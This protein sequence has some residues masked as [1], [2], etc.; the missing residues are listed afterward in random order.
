MALLLAS[1]LLLLAYSVITGSSIGRFV[2]LLPLLEISY[3]VS[4]GRGRPAVAA[5]WSA[6]W[7]STSSAHG[8]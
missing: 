2:V 7:C 8:C 4:M 5:P 1:A 6:Q 3:A